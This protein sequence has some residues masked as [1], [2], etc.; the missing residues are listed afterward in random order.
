MYQR[1]SFSVSNRLANKPK[2]L[3]F[4]LHKPLSRVLKQWSHVLSV[5]SRITRQ[6]QTLVLNVPPA[7]T[8]PLRRRERASLVRLAVSLL[9]WQLWLGVADAQVPSSIAGFPV[10][11]VTLASKGPVPRHGA[12]ARY[13][14]MGYFGAGPQVTSGTQHNSCSNNH[15]S[16]SW[17]WSACP[18][19][20]CVCSNMQS[21]CCYGAWIDC[22]W[23]SST[24]RKRLMCKFTSGSIPLVDSAGLPLMQLHPACSTGQP[25]S[26]MLWGPGSSSPDLVHPTDV[27]RTQSR[28]RTWQ[29]TAGCDAVVILCWAAQSLVH[30]QELPAACIIHQV[31]PSNLAAMPTGG[32]Q[33]RKV[34]CSCSCQRTRDLQHQAATHLPHSCPSPRS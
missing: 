12:N 29:P 28:P 8:M 7:A 6:P 32:L 18:L 14:A 10:A 15:C 23:P 22:A 1:C 24:S 5:L 4:L 20:L 30:Q 19:Q 21:S 9:A 13:D 26:L 27:I 17:L 33:C 11:N 3:P 16:P 34:S 31:L 2:Y 25:T